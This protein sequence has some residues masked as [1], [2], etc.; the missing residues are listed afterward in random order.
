MVKVYSLFTSKHAS[1]IN[2]SSILSSLLSIKN[3]ILS[4]LSG[5]YLLRQK[6]SK[7][8]ISLNNIK[9]LIVNSISSSYLLKLLVVIYLEV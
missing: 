4:N 2:I 3:N 6:L 7:N 9:N 5:I 8:I 1:R